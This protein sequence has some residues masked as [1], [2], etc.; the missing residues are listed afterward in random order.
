VANL[1]GLFLFLDQLGN[2][3]RRLCALF[4]PG[5]DLV[6]IKLEPSGGGTWVISP[7]L[8]DVPAIARKALVTYDDPV[9]GFLFGPVSTQSNDYAHTCLLSP[10]LERVGHSTKQGSHPQL[11]HP[12]HHLFHLHELFH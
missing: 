2:R 7:D 9:K 5:I 8:L 11:V 10:L 12:L 3:L 1:A 6:T 4:D